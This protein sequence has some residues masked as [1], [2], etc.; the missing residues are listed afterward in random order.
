MPQNRVDFYP[1]DKRRIWVGRFH[2]LKER[3]KRPPK[4]DLCTFDNALNTK[5]R[6]R[7]RSENEI[8]SHVRKIWEEKHAELIKELISC[9]LMQLRNLMNIIFRNIQL[10]GKEASNITSNSG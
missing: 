9:L 3:G 7:K 5:N 10:H 1:D 4:A 6:K 2:D 8:F